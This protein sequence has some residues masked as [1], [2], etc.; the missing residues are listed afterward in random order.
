MMVNRSHTPGPWTWHDNIL[1]PPAWASDL[2]C[3]IMN[4]DGCTVYRDSPVDAF[5]AEIKANKRLIAAAPELLAALKSHPRS[6]RQSGGWAMKNASYMHPSL[7]CPLP[8]TNPARGYVSSADTD[9]RATFAQHMLP[10]GDI[11][12]DYEIVEQQDWLSAPG[13]FR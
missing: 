9:I 1:E 8:I 11:R 6:H 3:T 13:G 10:V 7:W 5:Q 2:V 12:D 4:D